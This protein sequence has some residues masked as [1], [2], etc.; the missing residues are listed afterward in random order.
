MR[1]PPTWWHL[2][3]GD[4]VEQRCPS[5]IEVRLEALLQRQPQRL[6]QVYLLRAKSPRDPSDRGR[7]LR[8]LWEHIRVVG[9]GEFKSTA[10]PFRTGD[11]YRLAGCGWTW[12]HQH[13]ELA[14]RDLTLVLIVADLNDAL[15]DELA[16]CDAAL[17]ALGDG[18][19]RARVGGLRMIVVGLDAVAEAEKDD[20]VRV[21][22]HADWPSDYGN[23]GTWNITQSVHNAPSTARN[24]A[25]PSAAF[26]GG[27]WHD[28]TVAGRFALDL[29][30]GPSDWANYVGFRCVTPR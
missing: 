2:P 28:G 8:G 19:H 10:R 5:W 18:Y 23:D 3:I 13:P 25:L 16:R 26:R 17:S 24:S 7:V 12:L 9:L 20:Y 15:R 11:L 4:L 1:K 29:N 22:G 30:S 21:F 27:S 6:D 14:P